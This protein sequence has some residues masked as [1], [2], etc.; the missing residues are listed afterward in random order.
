MK[1]QPHENMVLTIARQH[2][3]DGD[4]DSGPNMLAVLVQ[5]IERLT[6]GDDQ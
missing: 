4:S 5:T 3:Q 6:E 2:V 1:L